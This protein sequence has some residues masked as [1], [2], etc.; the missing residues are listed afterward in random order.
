MSSITRSPSPIDYESSNKENSPLPIPPRCTPIPALTD[1][2]I[3]VDQMVTSGVSPGPRI[4]LDRM[5][6]RTTVATLDAFGDNVS[7]DQLVAMVRALANTASERGLHIIRLL[8][9]ADQ[10]NEEDP[11]KYSCPNGFVANEG[12]AGPIAVPD[13]KGGNVHAWW[14]LMAPNYQVEGLP[15]M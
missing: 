13:Y 3:Q 10:A 9:E 4:T 15:F 5:S 11:I 7:N 2:Q 12:Q 6:P 14:I 8:E 1:L